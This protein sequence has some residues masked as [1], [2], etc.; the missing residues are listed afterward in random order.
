MTR[1]GSRPFVAL[2][3]SVA[4]IGVAAPALAQ[5]REKTPK[6]TKSQ[7]DEIP[8]PIPF[9]ELS[10]S[11]HGGVAKLPWFEIALSF[12]LAED[13]ALEIGPLRERFN[14]LVLALASRLEGQRDPHERIGTLIQ[15]MF[16]ENSFT[17]SPAEP[18]RTAAHL[19][20]TPLLTRR[21]SATALVWLALS[22]SE[23]AGVADGI[24]VAAREHQFVRFRIAG[25]PLNVDVSKGGQSITDLDYRKRFGISTYAAQRGIYLSDLSREEALA[26]LLWLKGRTFLEDDNLVQARRFLDLALRL[27]PTMP[28]ALFDRGRVE[29]HEE[30]WRQ[31]ELDFYQA[32][33][34]DPAWTPPRIK[35]A[36]VL[37]ELDQTA[38][39]L[40]ELQVAEAKGGDPKEIL[41][42]MSLAHEK[43]GNETAAVD[44]LD[45]YVALE[46]NEALRAKADAQRREITS[47]EHLR[48]LEHPKATYAD[49]FAAVDSLKR[50]RV[51]ESIPVLVRI[52]G[53]KN[54]K[55]RN[56]V[57]KALEHI[58]G[59][60]LGTEPSDW[61]A[62]WKSTGAEFQVPPLPAQD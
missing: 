14:D 34:Q 9:G 15:F 52:L 8:G 27:V 13:P 59:H 1:F 42:E 47:R 61:D 11:E 21:G 57:A 54:W 44:A 56:F 17:I 46:A 41:L 28:L 5:D 49:R 36:R 3:L 10:H 60:A 38:E 18:G 16:V 43:S 30:R 25:A 51:K 40:A 20:T 37:M 39:A 45:R 7:G 26:R 50:L 29:M 58:T 31:A 53:D 6:D 19:I 35:R 24:L 12:A 23:A 2:V 4:L 62:W 32:M 22:L 48:M 33:V 55:F